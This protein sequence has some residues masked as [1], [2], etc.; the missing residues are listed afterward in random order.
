MDVGNAQKAARKLLAVFADTRLQEWD[1]DHMAQHYVHN[2]YPLIDMV[3]RVLT[4]DDMVRYHF[5]MVQTRSNDEQYT[6]F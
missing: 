5:D 4:F 3:D 2:A 1:I 6:L